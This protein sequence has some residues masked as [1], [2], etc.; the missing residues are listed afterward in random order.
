M[1]WQLVLVKNFLLIHFICAI[2]PTLITAIVT[3]AIIVCVRPCWIAIVWFLKPFISLF[4]HWSIQ[5]SIDLLFLSLITAQWYD[6]FARSHLLAFS[7]SFITL[8]HFPCFSHVSLHSFLNNQIYWW[9]FVC[10]LFLHSLK[11]FF[12][13]LGRK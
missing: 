4:L 2:S 13:F 10:F 6:S 12:H 9:F 5:V 1:E 11:L 3:R 8:I 7:K